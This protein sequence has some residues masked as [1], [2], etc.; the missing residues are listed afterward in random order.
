MLNKNGIRELAYLAR[1]DE[2]RPIDGY[3][4]VEY[5]RTNGWW[6]IVAKDAF[7]VGDLAIYFEVDSKVPADNPAFAFLQKRNYKVK[8]LRMCKVVSQGLLMPLKDF[9]WTLDNEGAEVRVMDHKGGLH[10]INDESCFVT[11]L[12]GVTYAEE[13]DNKR[14]AAFDEANKYRAMMSRRPEL[15]KRSWVKWMM[16][17]E[18]GKKVMFFFF[19]KKRDRDNKTSWPVGKFPGVNKTDQE[20]CENMPWILEDKTPWIVTEKCD[21]SSATYIL[22]KKPFG[23]YEFYVC[24][25]NVRMLNEDQTSYF[26]EYNP[27]WECAKK[28]DI[29]NKMKDYLKQSGCHWVC[30][31]GEAV[32]PKLQGNPHNVKDIHLFLFHM[33]DDKNGRYTIPKLCDVSEYYD[34]EHVPVISTNYIL[35]DSMEEFKAS[36]DGCYSPIVTEGQKGIRREGFVYYNSI[37]PAVSFKNVSREY[38]LKKGK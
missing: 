27:Y 36:A 24:S 6:C 3:D 25:R 20:R 1:I 10:S 32:G 29:E 16:K 38:L 19:G 11:K 2:I 28:Y 9:G 22:E 7:K 34:M 21:G 23:K 37:N 13:E 15:F 33:T 31:Q 14:K 17:R 26:G 12:L 18:W 8:T 4:R 35:P 5:A 30:W